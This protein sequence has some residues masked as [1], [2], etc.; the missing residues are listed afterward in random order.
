[1]AEERLRSDGPEVTPNSD[2]VKRWLIRIGA[3]LL[4]FLIGFVPMWLNNRQLNRSLEERDRELRRGRIQN[5]LASAA[6]YARRGEYETA[7]QNTSS[8]YTELSQEMDKGANSILTEQE[9]LAMNTVLV[10]RDEMIT[11]LSRNDPAAGERLSNVFV[12]YSNLIHGK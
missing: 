5:V 8:F 4:A 6:I 7:R 12:E 2:A 1:M 9:R 10:E 3:L 11:L